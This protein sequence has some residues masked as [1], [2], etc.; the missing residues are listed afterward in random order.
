MH[1]TPISL[2]PHPSSVPL[3][4]CECGTIACNLHVAK[5]GRLGTERLSA[6]ESW[7]EGGL[8]PTEH[9]RIKCRYIL[10]TCTPQFASP[11]T[12]TLLWPP[13]CCLQQYLP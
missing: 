2:H 4:R 8:P 1:A 11:H 10:K 3:R 13:R 6:V 12:R 7:A 9:P 5:G